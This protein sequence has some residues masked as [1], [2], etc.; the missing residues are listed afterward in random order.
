M[1]PNE[2]PCSP[3]REALHAVAPIAEAHK[4]FVLQRDLHQALERVARLE[5]RGR[6]VERELEKARRHLA[7]S[8]AKGRRRLRAMRLEVLAVE[9][10]CRALDEV[11]RALLLTIEEAAG[12]ELTE[13]TPAVGVW[14]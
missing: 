6:V 2:V 12:R 3:F 5:C 7:R 10:Q 1:P 13:P 8:K 4:I 11:C 14:P 9:A